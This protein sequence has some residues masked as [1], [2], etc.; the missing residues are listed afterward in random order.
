MKLSPIYK[1]REVYAVAYPTGHRVDD[2]IELEFIE[3]NFFSTYETAY[4]FM[5]SLDRKSFLDLLVVK[6]YGMGHLTVK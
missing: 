5:E 2:E 4:K 1:N 3:E 6:V